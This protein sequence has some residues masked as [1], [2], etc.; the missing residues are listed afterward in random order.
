MPPLNFP[1]ETIVVLITALCIAVITL[2]HQVRVLTGRIPAR[3]PLRALDVVRAA[4]GRGAE[5]G[6]AIHLS[7]G[8]GTIGNSATTAETVASLLAVERVAG[9]A[10]LNGAPVLAS[11]GDAVS[12]LALRGI[13]RQAYQRAGQSQDYNPAAVQLVAHQD[14]TAYAVGATTFSARQRLE[15]SQLIG[16]FGQEF[17]LLS[18]DG[19]QRDIPHVAGATST[20][21]LPIMLISS[22]ATLIGEEVFAAEAY[23]TRTAAPQAR[24]MTQDLLRTVLILVLIGFFVYNV[25][26]LSLG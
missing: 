4:L 8:A 21:A 25:I 17:L 15:A 2:W 10:A 19:A 12:Y 11:S 18:E 24:L 20:T 7:S 13:I 6:R 23:L 16:S 3:R 26:R 1:S 14:P 5:T 9:E 22:P